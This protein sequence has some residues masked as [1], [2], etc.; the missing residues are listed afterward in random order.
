[1]S[2]KYIQELNATSLKMRE[3]S[4]ATTTLKQN[5]TKRRPHVK[6][7][8]PG[9]PSAGMREVR[10]RWIRRD[11]Y[12]YCTISI[13]SAGHD[14][15]YMPAKIL[16][17]AHGGND[18]YIDFFSADFYDFLAIFKAFFMTSFYGFSTWPKWL[19]QLLDFGVFGAAVTRYCQI[20]RNGTV[21]LIIN[22]PPAECLWFQGG[23]PGKV[24]PGGGARNPCRKLNGGG[25]KLY[26]HWYLCIGL[27]LAHWLIC[28]HK[29]E[30]VRICEKSV[31]TSCK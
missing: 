19:L 2:S 17:S 26:G 5:I 10:V 21:S 18:R 12:Y 29:L 6:Q 4:C 31:D 16:H 1:M 20:D 3:W 8:G 9:S 28:I 7:E 23:I 24:Q 11:W 30:C 14:T 13:N 25:K 15:R 22:A 27:T